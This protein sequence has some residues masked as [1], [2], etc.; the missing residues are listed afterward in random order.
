M[1]T[2]QQQVALSHYVAIVTKYLPPTNHRG[3]RIKV[4]HSDAKSLTVSWDYELDVAENHAQAVQT[5]LDHMEWKGTW[6]VGAIDTGYVAVFNPD[7]PKVS[8][9]SLDLEG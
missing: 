5:Y 9:R 6:T 3:S 2:K 4:W 8:N 7:S 1:E